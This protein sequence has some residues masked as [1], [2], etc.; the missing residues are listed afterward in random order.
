[1]ELKKGDDNI[2]LLTSN[3]LSVLGQAGTQFNLTNHIDLLNIILS[4]YCQ[5]NQVTGV[6]NLVTAK[7]ATA[8]SI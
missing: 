7:R 4:L 5:P 8:R 3:C 1:M 2:L 6:F